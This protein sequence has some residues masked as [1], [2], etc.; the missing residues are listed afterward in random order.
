MNR[1]ARVGILVASVAIFCYAG[2]GHVLGRTPD[3]KAYKS[4]T[5]YG[6]VLQKIQSD[7][8]DE[9]NM[10]L[11][12]AG[13]LH[14]LLESLDAQSS[15]LTPREYTEYKQKAQSSGTGETGLNLSKRFGYVIVISVLPESPAEK[16]GIRSGDIFESVGGFTT[17]DMSV[18]QA[19]NLLNGPAG[20]GVKVGVI[21]R[22]R[23]QPEEIDLVRQKLTLAKITAQ[24]TDPDIL[25]LRVPSL[26]AG[27]ADEIRARLADADKQGVHKLILDLRECGRGPVS[28]AVSVARLFV[29]S[30]T[31]A[32]LRGQTVSAQTF[33]A[34]PSKVVWRNPVSILIDGSTSGAAEVLASA[35]L[36]NRRGDVIGERTFG[37][38][39]EQKL[40]TLD[41]GSALFLT[42]A[43]YYN[44]GGKSIL[45]DGVT[46]S[47]V[48]R[49][50]AE[51]DGDVSDDS[52]AS[53]KEEPSGPHPLSP[54]DPIFHKAL[55]LL[56]APAKKAA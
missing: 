26:D 5:V 1:T 24:K 49:A 40:I 28:E 22:G 53:P 35:I 18:G 37:L 34:E 50:V 21:R 27:R 44:A 3:D 10:R 6:E 4:L 39:S 54:E 25:A 46:P 11:V 47:E 7:Y 56:R 31:I 51:D 48:V 32:T 9:P 38:A 17:R 30:G 42:V 2:I 14:G 8:V 36:A 43:N 29:S 41:D 45:D 13:S 12:T 19:L 16:A 15:Y 52:S 33:S 23:A 55:D 20:S